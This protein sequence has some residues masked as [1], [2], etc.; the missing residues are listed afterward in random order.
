ME[1][2]TIIYWA[3]A[4][5]AIYKLVKWLRTKQTRYIPKEVKMAVVKHYYGMCAVCSDTTED[6]FEFHHRLEFSNGGD[7]S[8][9]NIV[10]LCPKHHAVVTRYG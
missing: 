10:P 1:I 5:Y 6:L 8:V 2:M 3:V 4:L 7:N 9:K